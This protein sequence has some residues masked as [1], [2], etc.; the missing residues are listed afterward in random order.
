MLKISSEDFVS[1]I[2]T[3]TKDFLK[4]KANG[5]KMYFTLFDICEQN[6]INKEDADFIYTV[7]AQPIF[8]NT[9]KNLYLNTF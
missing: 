2:E 1:I 5:Q 8:E 9:R 7:I 3:Y 4:A 6:A